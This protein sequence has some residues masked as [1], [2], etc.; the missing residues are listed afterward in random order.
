MKNIT[1]DDV[2][3]RVMLFSEELNAK[4]TA[5]FDNVVTSDPKIEYKMTMQEL[6]SLFLLK[7][8]SFS[9]GTNLV[10]IDFFIKR[11]FFNNI[12]VFTL[13]RGA[14]LYDIKLSENQ[15]NYSIG[16]TSYL[17]CCFIFVVSFISIFRLS[18]I[19]TPCLTALIVGFNFISEETLTKLRFHLSVKLSFLNELRL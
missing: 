13:E 3:R 14:A 11:N 8:D 10:D 4:T 2:F 15:R 1:S 7:I 19:I 9:R 5:V 12:N 16:L 18:R 17:I 6:T